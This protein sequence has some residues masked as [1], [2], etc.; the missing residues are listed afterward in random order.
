MLPRGELSEARDVGGLPRVAPLHQR[1]QGWVRVG[2]L[3]GLELG[4]GW[5]S[6]TCISEVRPRC[7]VAPVGWNSSE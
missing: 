1:S 2:S 7:A 4:L 3:L 6:L 5:P